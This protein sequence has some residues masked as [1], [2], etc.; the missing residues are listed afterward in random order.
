MDC[1]LRRFKIP[2]DLLSSRRGGAQNVR[3]RTFGLMLPK[4]RNAQIGLLT[5]V[6]GLASGLD[7]SRTAP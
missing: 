6:I 7:E 5:D 2:F 4:P 1:P 3:N